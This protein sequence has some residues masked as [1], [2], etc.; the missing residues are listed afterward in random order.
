MAL[1]RGEA[2][3]KRY[4]GEGTR[5]RLQPANAAMKPLTYDARDVTVQGVVTGLMRSYGARPAPP[6]PPAPRGHRAGP[7]R[8]RGRLAATPC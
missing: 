1:V 3:L 6:G 7:G 4:Y 5:V 8:F 2:T